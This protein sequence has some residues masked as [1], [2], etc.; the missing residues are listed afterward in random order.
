MTLLKQ[1]ICLLFLLPTQA[2]AQVD[3][4]EDTPEFLSPQV[5]PLYD[6]STKPIFSHEF[7]LIKPDGTIKILSL[8]DTAL[9]A[10]PASTMKLFTGWWAFQEAIRDSD[11]LSLMLRTS[12]NAMAQST[13]NLLGTPSD[14]EQ[15]YFNLGLTVN[16]NSFRVADGSGLS[17]ANKSNCVVQIQLLEMIQGDPQFETFKEFLAQ[18]GENGT[19]RNRLHGLKGKVFAKTG[20]LNKTA[21]LSGFIEAPQ[22]TILFC[23]LSDFINHSLQT[24]RKR[25]DAMVIKNYNL[26]L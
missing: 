9:L 17:Y 23:V 25:I 3:P 12:S 18:P 11:Y 21:A 16:E 5:D 13:L 4:Y 2:Y 6:K 19:L 26:A 15:Y 1:V 24:E 22:G 10:K 20:T 8:K 14:M 7:K